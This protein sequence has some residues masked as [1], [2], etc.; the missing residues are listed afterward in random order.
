MACE[1]ICDIDHGSVTTMILTIVLPTILGI[2]FIIQSKYLFEFWGLKK[3]LKYYRA[4][5]ILFMSLTLMVWFG[6]MSWGI[7]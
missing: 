4:Y 5:M 2:Y 1:E 7:Y 6:I 3:N